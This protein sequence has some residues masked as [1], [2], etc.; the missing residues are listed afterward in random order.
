MV[1][2]LLKKVLPDEWVNGREPVVT[3]HP[4]YS[5]QQPLSW[6]K[7]IWGYLGTYDRKLES[8]VNLPLFPVADITTERKSFKMARVKSSCS[9]L[10]TDHDSASRETLNLLE[11]L[12]LQIIQK[13]PGFI[14]NH[15]CVGSTHVF[16][17]N[18]SGIISLLSELCSINGTMNVVSRFQCF[19][20]Q[21]IE[22]E[23]RSM[24][25][26]SL[27]AGGF[28]DTVKNMLSKFPIFRVA[29]RAN[30]SIST[31]DVQHAGFS[32]T[33]KNMLGKFPI[34]GMTERAVE[35]VCTE[36]VQLAVTDQTDLPQVMPKRKLILLSAYD[37]TLADALGIRKLSTK[38][39]CEEVIIPEVCEKKL[40][41]GDLDKTMEYLLPLITSGKI[42]SNE[43]LGHLK[44]VPDNRG[45]LH[46]PTDLFDP[47]NYTLVK[48]FQ[49]ENV[50]PSS[51]YKQE[52]HIS[53]LRKIGLKTEKN[54]VAADIFASI[55]TIE[56]SGNMNKVTKSQAIAKFLYQNPSLLH[57]KVKTGKGSKLRL[58]DA[59]SEKVWIKSES[60][61][62]STYPPSLEWYEGA[63]F[64]KPSEIYDISQASL[65]GSLRPVV[66]MHTYE[67]CFPLELSQKS[68]DINDVI[69]HFKQ[70]VE[71]YTE[72]EK[73]CFLQIIDKIYA[74]LQ[75]CEPERVNS[76]LRRVNMEE[77]IWY[78]NGFVSPKHAII[79][80]YRIDLSPY[81][82]VLPEESKKYQNLFIN[83]GMRGECHESLLTEVLLLV[84]QK[85]S[86]G[87]FKR[88]ENKQ[89]LHLVCQILEEIK[90]SPTVLENSEIYVPVYSN[91]SNTL[92]LCPVSQCSYSDTERFNDFYDESFGVDRDS[93]KEGKPMYLV[94]PA[95]SKQTAKA[96]CIPSLTSCVLGAES[97]GVFEACGQGEPL[98]RRLNRLLEDYKDGFSIPKE[99]IQNADDARATE[100]CFLYDERKNDHC[101][102]LLIDTGMKSCQGPALWAYNDAMFSEEDFQNITKL[103]GATKENQTDKIGKFGL[104]FN[105]VYNLTDVPSFVSKDK[106]VIFDPH[107]TYLG[108]AIRDK[109]K[110][111][112]KINIGGRRDRLKH[113]KDQFKPYHEVF[114]C[115]MDLS[116]RMSS[117]DGTLFR[118]PLRTK[119]QSVKSE[120]KS[121]HYDNNEMKELLQ[122]LVKN[123]HNLLL[124]TQNVRKISIY[125]LPSEA[126]S[127][128]EMKELATIKR[129]QIHLHRSISESVLGGSILEVA[130]KAVNNI[131]FS[132]QNA[133][134]SL[135][136]AEE[137]AVGMNI[138]HHGK[139]RF[140]LES[141]YDDK[142]L[143]SI[144]SSV[145]Q[146]ESLDV[147]RNMKGLSPC[148]SVA[149]HVSKTEYEYRF[150]PLHS[151]TE[152]GIQG[153]LFCYL[154][155]P[156]ASGLPVQVNG[157]FAVN[158][159]RQALQEVSEDD[160]NRYSKEALW[161]TALLK[162]SV[163]RSYLGALNDLTKKIAST[164]VINTWFNL[165]PTFDASDGS[166]LK[167]SCLRSLIESFYERIT[168][169]GKQWKIFPSDHG[170][171]SWDDIAFL[172]QTFYKKAPT[173]DAAIHVSKLFYEDRTIV[174]IPLK[175]LCTFEET[176][177][178]QALEAS[179]LDVVVFLRQV[180]F[181][182]LSHPE[183]K[184][185]ERDTLL[186]FCLDNINRE[187]IKTLLE[188]SACIP[189][190]PNGKVRKPK[191]LV[192]RNSIVGALYSDEDEVFPMGKEFESHL[193]SLRQLGMSSSQITWENLLERAKSVEAL[194]LASME[195]ACQRTRKVCK[196]LEEKVKSKDIDQ[197]DSLIKRFKSVRF[198]PILERKK[199][200]SNLK[201]GGDNTGK[202][203]SG[204]EIYP[205]RLCNLVGCNAA[206]MDETDNGCAKVKKDVLN[207]LGICQTPTIEQVMTQF[208]ILITHV[209]SSILS[210]RD[211]V[212]TIDA[213]T[214]A[215]YKFIDEKREERGTFIKQ[216]LSLREIIFVCGRFVDPKY[217]SFELSFEAS[218]YL[219]KLPGKLTSNFPTLMEA[220]GVEREFD[221]NTFVKVLQEIGGTKQSKPFDDKE[222][223]LVL[224]IINNNMLKSVKDSEET[225]VVH[226]PDSQGILCESRELC[227]KDVT[228][229]PDEP[230]IRYVHKSISPFTALDLGALTRRHSFVMQNSLGLPFGQHEKL[231]HRLRR[232]MEGYPCDKGILKE[233]LQNADDARATE[234][235]FVLDPREHGKDRLFSEKWEPLQGPALLVYNNSC[236]TEEDI[237]GIQNLGE[238]SKLMDPARTGQYG[239]GFNVVYHLTDAP[240]FLTFVE[241]RGNVLC[242]F[243]PQCRYFEGA[244]NLEPG[245]MFTNARQ[246][247]SNSFTDVY[248]GYLPEIFGEEKSTIFRLPLRNV[249]MASG[250]V[251]S[252]KVISPDKIR[253][254]TKQFKDEAEEVV[255]FLNHVKHI[256][257]SEVDSKSGKLKDTFSIDVKMSKKD[258]KTHENFVRKSL[259]MAD[260]I[261]NICNDIPFEQLTN[262]EIF[263][264]DMKVITSTGSAQDWTVVQKI[265]FMDE[266]SI[267]NCIKEHIIKGDLCLL[268]K[269]GIAFPRL[270][271]RST[272]KMKAFCLL[273]LPLETKLP[274]HVNGH[275][276]LDHETRRNLWHDE[277]AGYKSE[278]NQSMIKNVIVPCYTSSV[279]KAA[280]RIPVNCT[281]NEAML[282]LSKFFEI[283]PDSAKANDVYWKELSTGFY[284]QLV[285]EYCPVMPVV[286]PTAAIDGQ[287]RRSYEG[288]ASVFINWHPPRAEE[289]APPFYHADSFL[290][291]RSSSADKGDR[292][293]E[294]ND[295]KAIKDF[296]LNIGMN[297]HELA[298]FILKNFEISKVPLNHLEPEVVL[299]YISHHADVLRSIDSPVQE[300]V[301]KSVK[302][303]SLLLRFSLQD[304]TGPSML[305]GTPLLITVDEYIRKFEDTISRYSNDFAE[306]MPD[307]KDL[308]IHQSVMSE[309]N[310]KKFTKEQMNV[311]FKEFE[312]DDICSYLPEILPPSL[313]KRDKH[314]LW[315]PAHG[316]KPDKKWL[317]SFWKFLSRKFKELPENDPQDFHKKDPHEEVTKFL[318]PL[319]E[320]CLLPASRRVGKQYESYLVPLQLA[321]CVLDMSTAGSVIVNILRKIGILELNYN[322]LSNSVYDIDVL[323]FATNTVAK[324]KDGSSL[325][326]SLHWQ[327]Q[328]DK[329]AFA[330]LDVSDAQNLLTYLD[331]FVSKYSGAEKQMLMELPLFPDI[332]KNLCSISGKTVYII[333]SDVPTEGL[334]EWNVKENIVLL[335]VEHSQMNKVYNNLQLKNCSLID[336]YCDIIFVRFET[337]RIKEMAKH[338]RF[339]MWHCL[340]D[341]KL[342]E[343]SKA[344]IL[345]A[346]KHLKFLKRRNDLLQAK[347]F[348]DPDNRVFKEMLPSNLFPPAP[349][350]D[351]VWLKVLRMI[352][353]VQS[354]SSDMF[355][356]F[357]NEVS[358][359]EDK[360]KIK[361]KSTILLKYLQNNSQLK[362]DRRLLN[363][364]S[365]VPF[366]VSDEVPQKFTN[367]SP[368]HVPENSLIALKGALHSNTWETSWTVCTLLPLYVRKL[369]KLPFTEL[370]VREDLEILEVVKHL[371]NVINSNQ[372]V[373]K[374]DGIKAI[375]ASYEFRT[376]LISVVKKCYELTSEYEDSL[377]P[378]TV[379]LLK[380]AACILVDNDR[381][382]AKPSLTTTDENAIKPYIWNVS[383]ALGKYF[384]L[385][386]KLGVTKHLST[387]Q[388]ADVLKRIKEECHDSILDPNKQQCVYLAISY[389]AMALGQEQGLASSVLYLPTASIFGVGIE[390]VKSTDLL[391]MDDL[392]FDNRLQNFAARYLISELSFDLKKDTQTDFIKML[393][394]HLPV[395]LRPKYLSRVVHEKLVKA[396]R[397][398]CHLSNQL[399]ETLQSAEFSEG[400]ARLV[401]DQKH[402]DSKKVAD[403]LENLTSLLHNIRTVTVQEISTAL[404][405][406]D[407]EIT[408]SQMR[409]EVFVDNSD[410]S[411]LKIYISENAE[412]DNVTCSKIAGNLAK[413]IGKLFSNTHYVAYLVSLLRERPE[414]ISAFLDKME[415]S[416][417][418][419]TQKPGDILRLPLPGEYVPL[420]L[421]HLL[422]DEFHDF[423]EDEYVAF[424]VEDPSMDGEGGEAVYIFAKIVQK[425]KEK[426][427][428][429]SVYRIKV[430][431]NTEKD[432]CV[433]ELYKFSHL[434]KE[435]DEAVVP[436]TG[437]QTETPC[438]PI[439]DKSLEEVLEEITETLEEAWK[440]AEMKR[441][442]V[443]KRCYL[444][445]HP[446]K[447]PSEKE[448]FCNEVCKHIQME[449]QRL[450]HELP[451]QQKGS[452]SGSPRY[453]PFE[454]LFSHWNTRARSHF[455]RR[456]SYGRS[457]FGSS[458][459]HQSFRRSNFG[460]SRSHQSWVPPA[461]GGRNPQPREAKRWYQQ[462]KYDFA[463]FSSDF[464]SPSYE[465]ICFKCH[466][467]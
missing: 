272:K 121:L 401:K 285:Q 264:Y 268:P 95:V 190:Y 158:S 210:N 164:S 403:E 57:Q 250:S 173:S 184:L 448:E 113:F 363:N 407:K 310:R 330:H 357:V 116:Q 384:G 370:G 415:I 456:Q 295:D 112:V 160:K 6:L 79:S 15:P 257:I 76:A 19:P 244:T 438:Q 196:F 293:K 120:I 154:P 55:C 421:H 64:H 269:G 369:T 143:W 185:A 193:N 442:R 227:I 299:S 237:K 446:D 459:S 300:T 452:P 52:P 277:E 253:D 83:C 24:L 399:T 67:T 124:F 12:G 128:T 239:V 317:Y 151:N 302:I 69:H 350:S 88:D 238:G 298:P 434:D 123:G 54:V 406:E 195:L 345:N 234:L 129:E 360:E 351:N 230:G 58:K 75:G 216:R 441:K 383:V 72:S 364:I 126:K 291:K 51:F 339:V 334:T 130:S 188:N 398:E 215:I 379:K 80:K 265:G 65:I 91:D 43:E 313:R 138:T 332:G 232:I 221:S 365:N 25:S 213:I 119:E 146:S 127:P 303:I 125:H 356:K 203:L 2:Q 376:V 327:Y 145:G 361:K 252:S 16:P 1:I 271:Q 243:D 94:H 170:W 385:F 279:M 450:Q 240:S 280:Q 175:T 200:W 49:G 103:S 167:S 214:G 20:F 286:R 390:L 437:L 465:W 444:R 281:V 260:S 105:T 362:K 118:F 102:N 187:D 460:S 273:P 367:I 466:Q 241:N 137:V 155:L 292:K 341:E 90:D 182:N 85:H 178:Q 319:S 420:E 97:F 169:D 432:L 56:E 78:G 46:M 349:Y 380:D 374:Y 373:S 77:W 142:T 211:H 393:M 98:T 254:L 389:L 419:N 136:I 287:T 181:P 209:N 262:S 324:I 248:S 290:I 199:S 92:K 44:F 316:K 418:P 336:L 247:M 225:P 297:F 107:T 276:I 171:L 405:Y 343:T 111:G 323:H 443:L 191:D 149:I 320:W 176:G 261:K 378:D 140:N 454:D 245:R 346:M 395:A 439:P 321:Y 41:L 412:C 39:L 375:P 304:C 315:P 344:R 284:Q 358:G 386:Q 462:A 306:L 161:N 429:Q 447:N 467:V 147:A 134:A 223:E 231:T 218:P 464:E 27:M 32:D 114:G 71:R 278:W 308:F 217:V 11:S 93:S 132:K 312:L 309:L 62:L 410:S 108:D 458:R 177:M 453:N 157:G 60:Q 416:R 267:S 359:Q 288:L 455:S 3:W 222:L 402:R 283:F 430:S 301:F 342:H 35:Y 325:L 371:I 449:V 311:L 318:R 333:S 202:F 340:N 226:L 89:D 366:L 242:L 194:S 53:A 61:K 219:Y 372:M 30:E 141:H 73:L 198:L 368:P 335:V 348:Y 150:H 152:N 296:L 38:Q 172:D 391:Y 28:S 153:H 440:L 100:I 331:P 115:N 289:K 86:E 436:Y 135:K 314:V 197:T 258:T 8:V 431:T 192:E 461:F 352:G 189:T 9:L 23:F 179:V 425:I 166:P 29:E 422:R 40:S 5:D 400:L 14:E 353:L 394:E 186:L 117:F 180:F 220:F 206:V 7:V 144:H 388:I 133:A 328:K 329:K 275:F 251:I 139:R 101:K 33:M 282:S 337:L 122:L 397:T 413:A 21:K 10:L 270:Q 106:L 263:S 381:K 236:F 228:W 428:L 59:I 208:E 159:S 445:W 205:Q 256:R 87:K 235:H 204:E 246:L 99:L 347:D 168:I 417:D 305:L 84:K 338:L 201:W 457:Y 18:P 451:R 22:K 163:A 423:E 165:W 249:S 433:T 392:R 174:S 70:V 404:F 408:G 233:L 266:N 414:D 131:D 26:Q 409:S 156:I 104:G 4:G 42:Q 426:G 427:P 387:V 377:N 36:D 96:L 74:Y 224:N 396:D 207:F 63:V 435:L 463:A 37:Q 322:I 48:L 45:C 17:G 109:S 307:R 183:M 34:L 50:F 212:E 294:R 82:R 66:S 68:P 162:D 355:N 47:A 13:L 354:V 326:K 31:E 424:E 259:A 229:M 255:L 148:S 274:V 382:L 110:P 411:V 81:I